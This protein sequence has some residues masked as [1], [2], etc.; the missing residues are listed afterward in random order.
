MFSFAK[1]LVDNIIHLWRLTCFFFQKN[2][3]LIGYPNS[4]RLILHLEHV[5]HPHFLKLAPTLGSFQSSIPHGDWRFHFFSKINFPKFRVHLDL[6]IHCWDLCFMRSLKIPED[7]L[8][9]WKCFV[10][11]FS[12]GCI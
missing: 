12:A 8:V 2:P 4:K 3:C 5:Q 1:K 6:H 7:M 9:L 11:F 10:P